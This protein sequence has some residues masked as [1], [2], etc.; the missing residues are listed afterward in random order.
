ML[1]FEITFYKQ[2][3]MR[4]L[5]SALALLTA[6][7][8]FWRIEYKMKSLELN[9]NFEGWFLEL[10][11]C[12]WVACINVLP[13]PPFHISCVGTSVQFLWS[14]DANCSIYIISIYGCHH[15]ACNNHQA[16]SNTWLVVYFLLLHVQCGW[17][18]TC[19]H[20]PKYM[21]LA[22]FILFY[23]FQLNMSVI[24]CFG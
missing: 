5:R 9:L 3:L 12:W 10:Y 1:R 18:S 4:S 11:S 24:G 20:V 7:F 16:V 22:F 17:F 23:I 21:Y 15:K 13:H 6:Q 8:R 19:G 2:F 14:T